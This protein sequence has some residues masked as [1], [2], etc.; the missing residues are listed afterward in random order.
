MA[1]LVG[2]AQVADG[3]LVPLWAQ[4]YFKAEDFSVVKTAIEKAEANTHAE[5]V[6]I[7]VKSSSSSD[8]VPYIM[9]FFILSLFTFVI[10]PLDLVSFDSILI[11]ELAL[12]AVLIIA[13]MFSRFPAVQRLFLSQIRMKQQVEERALLEFY[14]S[15]TRKTQQSTGV[16]IFI[17]LMEHQA[18]IL[19]DKT[20]EQNSN[21]GIWDE[22]LKVLLQN[23]KLKKGGLAI[24]SAI[25]VMAKELKSLSPAQK[26]NPNE[27]RDRLVFKD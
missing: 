5:I 9:S 3:N 1:A 8:A 13:F 19:G 22:T 18:V 14:T 2:E 12:V 20:I 6:P 17:S 7:V 27:L 23:L 4:Q 25:E 24:Q 10:L 15:P 16:L 21:E 11:W 26:N